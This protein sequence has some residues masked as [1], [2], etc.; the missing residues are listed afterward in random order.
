MSSLKGKASIYESYLQR[1]DEID[2]ATIRPLEDRVLVRDIPDEEKVGAVYSP[3]T[4]RDRD[5]NR[6]GIVVAVGLGD[7]FYEKG[8]NPIT[9]EVIRRAVKGGRLPMEV[10]VGDRV[11]FNRRKDMEFF[12]EGERYNFVNEEQSILAVLE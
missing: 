6:R 10:K 2:P 4:A 12:F 9:G 8:K 5:L 1:I 11:I 7:R 3:E